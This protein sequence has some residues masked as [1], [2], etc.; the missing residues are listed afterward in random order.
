MKYIFKGK[1]VRSAINK[2]LKKLNL[3]KEDAVIE[4][5][6]EKPRVFFGI[7][8]GG[9]SVKVAPKDMAGDAD[10]DWKKSCRRV[11]D[12]SEKI[13]GMIADDATVSVKKKNSK[14]HVSINTEKSELIIG[15]RGSTLQAIEYILNLV[16]KRDP[17]TRVDVKVD[18]AGYRKNT[19]GKISDTVKKASSKVNKQKARNK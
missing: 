15:R 2:G 1:N 18:C 7:F 11:G 12:Y 8:G 19:K 4:I 17:S 3:S 9:T 6:K 10:V 13:A 5:I 16:I 14:V